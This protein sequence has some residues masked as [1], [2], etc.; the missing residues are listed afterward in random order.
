MCNIFENN[1]NVL[2]LREKWWVLLKMVAFICNPM[3]IF[4]DKGDTFNLKSVIN[5]KYLFLFEDL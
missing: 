5:Y 3:L 4:N 1:W 2:K